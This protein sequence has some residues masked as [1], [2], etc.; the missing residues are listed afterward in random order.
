MAP[1]HLPRLRDGAAVGHSGIQLVSHLTSDR[2]E[3]QILELRYGII[4][5]QALTPRKS[6][7]CIEKPPGET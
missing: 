6:L 4:R 1:S 7:A 3:T 2:T 5:A